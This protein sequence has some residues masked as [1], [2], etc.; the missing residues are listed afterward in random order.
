MTAGFSFDDEIGVEN[1][2]EYDSPGIDGIVDLEDV[3][4]FPGVLDFYMAN[5]ATPA[6][7][8]TIHYVEVEILVT[9]LSASLDYAGCQV[10]VIAGGIEVTLTNVEVTDFS[11]PGGSVSRVYA[12]A[13]LAS[14]PPAPFLVEGTLELGIQFVGEPV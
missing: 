12:Y 14:A 6:G 2:V 8:P 1:G 4:G 11:G 5:T 10:V 13:S 9:G 3:F 7:Q